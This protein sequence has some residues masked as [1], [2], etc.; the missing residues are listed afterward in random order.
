MTLD[1][2][3]CKVLVQTDDAGRVTA[4]NSDAFVSGDGWTAIDEGEGDR[5]RHAQNN[6]L[7]KPLTDER[8]VYR[9]KLVDGLVAQRTQAEMDADFDARP[10]PEPTA[11]EKERTLLK[12]QIQA[13]SD[14]NDFLEDCMAEMAGIVYA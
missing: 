14:R 10:A 12:A 11:E 8:G 1:T 5:Y 7:L 4:I 13:L 2:E 6:Y 3:S 9:Y